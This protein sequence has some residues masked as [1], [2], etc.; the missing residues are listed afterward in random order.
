MDRW[1]MVFDK[2][3]KNNMEV[4]LYFLRKLWEEFVL[5][6][7]VNYFDIT[8]FQRVGLGSVQD[9]ECARRNPV[10]GP[11]PPRWMPVPPVQHPP[12]G[13]NISEM[14]VAIATMTRHLV[15][16][17]AFIELCT[18]RTSTCDVG[19]GVGPSSTAAESS[20]GR[21]ERAASEPHKMPELWQH[22]LVADGG[23]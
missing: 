18:S 19:G 4:P 22:M 9:Q 20:T 8:E 10:L 6:L 16:H 12:I 7:H 11:H 17:S 13:G 5:G 14:W 1:F 21:L 3:P 2:A 23:Y 15:Q